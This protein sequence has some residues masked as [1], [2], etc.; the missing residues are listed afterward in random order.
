MDDL[1]V[2]NS[3]P[4]ARKG[5]HWPGVSLRRWVKP[6]LLMQALVFHFYHDAT[7]LSKVWKWPRGRLG[8][9]VYCG[10]E[11]NYNSSSIDIPFDLSLYIPLQNSLRPY[12]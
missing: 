4:C 3:G 2:S 8:C 5:S 6:S 1:S 9:L 7:I 11:N 10:C 12:S